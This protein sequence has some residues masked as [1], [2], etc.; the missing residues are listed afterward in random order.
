[1]YIPLQDIIW[2]LRRL[3]LPQRP[4]ADWRQLEFPGDDN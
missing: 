4:L 3:R 2:L 1:L